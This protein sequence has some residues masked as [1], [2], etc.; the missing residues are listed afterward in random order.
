[1]KRAAVL[2]IAAFYLLLTT[3]MFVCL[4]H[5]AGESFFQ[6]RMA[7]QAMNHDAHHGKQHKHACKDKD[8]DCCNKHGNYVIKENIKPAL[9]DVQAPQVA[10]LL[11][12]FNYVPVTVAYKAL[13][14]L[15]LLYG[16]A[17]PGISGKALSI[18]LRSL[19]I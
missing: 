10:M 19:Q 12:Q 11:Q 14:I 5:C 9:V 7:M 3:G 16:K 6:P 4:I 17:P 13:N 18:Q 1:M 8:C 2:S 15:P